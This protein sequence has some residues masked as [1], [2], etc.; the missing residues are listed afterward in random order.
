MHEQDFHILEGQHITL[1]ELGRELENITGRHIVDSTG[2]IK[3]VVAHLPN[4]DSDTD[5]FVATYQLDNHDFVDA[6][7][8]AA[9]AD[10]DQLKEIPVYIKLISYMSR[11]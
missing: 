1:P 2:T 10:R 8:I 6:T 7:F 9:K 5:T 3:R 4:F 11:A